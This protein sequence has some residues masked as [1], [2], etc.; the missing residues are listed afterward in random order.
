MPLQN[1]VSPT[2]AIVAD[3][4]RGLF[5]GNRGILHDDDRRLGPARWRH[6][7]WIVCVLAFKGRRR[8]VME[9]RCYTELF[10]LDE[11]VA[12]A[13]GHRP[14]AECRRARFHAF[15]AGWAKGTG[16]AGGMPKAADLDAM[17]H[18]ARVDPR[19][20]RQVTWEARLP[21]LPD[22]T[23][24]RLGDNMPRLVLGEALPA[25][26]PAGYRDAVKRPRAPVVTVLTP[27][28][29]VS[30]LAGGYMPALHPSAMERTGNAPPA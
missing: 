2:G 1:R 7:H 23:F 25:W 13:A 15:L 22:G 20:R 11:A 21:D 27:R 10:F 17:L 30:A 8:R 4:A 28:P 24:V 9:P 19:N 18:A 26:T 29:T 5:M 6:K 3:P 14:C 16:H 12:L